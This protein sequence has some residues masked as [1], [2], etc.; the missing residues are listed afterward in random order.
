MICSMVKGEPLS[1]CAPSVAWHTFTCRRTNVACSSPMQFNASSL[2]T[3]ST[4]RGGV[5]GILQH[6]RNSCLTV[7]FSANLFSLSTNLHY[8]LSTS[9]SIVIHPPPSDIPFPLQ[10]FCALPL[11]MRHTCSLTLP[12]ARHHCPHLLHHHFLLLCPFWTLWHCGLFH[13]FPPI[14][15]SLPAYRSNPTPP[16]RWGICSQ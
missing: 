14:H 15:Q 9:V 1:T 7:P 8:P 2:A 10:W 16:L 12:P 13:T 4:T 6:G 11:M 5:S 3:W